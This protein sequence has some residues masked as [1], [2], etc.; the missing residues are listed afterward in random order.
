MLFTR[1]SP[2]VLFLGNHAFL[3]AMMPKSYVTF[4]HEFC[5]AKTAKP[6]RVGTCNLCRHEDGTSKGIRHFDEY[7]LDATTIR[8]AM[9]PFAWQHRDGKP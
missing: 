5:D 6:L 3:D 1:A 4:T 9:S 7:A 2:Q 8:K